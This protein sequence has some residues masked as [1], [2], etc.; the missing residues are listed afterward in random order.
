MNPTTLE[1]LGTGIFAIA[2]LHTFLVQKILNLSHHFAKDSF[3]HGLLHLLSEIEIVFG[4]WAAVFLG[5]MLFISGSKA[6]IE[7]QEGLNFT[8][9]LFVFVIMVIAATRPVLGLA[10][11]GIQFVSA[12]LR[13]VFKTPEKLT[14]VLS[15]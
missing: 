11:D 8:E 1:I 14:D 13:K 12:C 7:F 9:P 5:C 6:T 10:R 3:M 2:I 4:A 15:S